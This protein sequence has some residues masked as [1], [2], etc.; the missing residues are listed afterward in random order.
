MVSCTKLSSE[1]TS[2]PKLFRPSASLSGK[3]AV[4]IIYIVIFYLKKR[5]NTMARAKR[6]DKKAIAIKTKMC[7]IIDTKQKATAHKGVDR[8]QE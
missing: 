3:S 4:I 5:G 8:L 6:T 2:Y 7:Y 1:S